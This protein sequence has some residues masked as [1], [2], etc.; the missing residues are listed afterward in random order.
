MQT[1]ISLLIHDMIVFFMFTS[2]M[3]KYLKNGKKPILQIFL[4]RTF[5]S[6][7]LL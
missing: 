3:L 4:I 7:E 6:L 5:Q 2:F 1:Q